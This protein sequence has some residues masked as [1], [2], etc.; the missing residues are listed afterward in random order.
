MITSVGVMPLARSLT[1]TP[2]DCHT[3]VGSMA[4]AVAGNMQTSATD[5]RT[6]ML[7]NVRRPESADI[8]W[9]F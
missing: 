2:T 4:C 8:R 9:T 3:S 5:A 1:D 6:S 7:T